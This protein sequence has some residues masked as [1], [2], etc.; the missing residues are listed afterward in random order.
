VVTSRPNGQGLLDAIKAAVHDN[1]QQAERGLDQLGRSGVQLDVAIVDCLRSGISGSRSPGVTVCCA[2]GDDGSSDRV[3]DGHAHVDFP[4]SSLTLWGAA[5]TPRRLGT[6][7]TKELSGMKRDRGRPRRP[8]AASS[9]CRL[10]KSHANV[11][12]SVNPGH[13]RDEASGHRGDAIRHRLY[14][15]IDDSSS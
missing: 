6:T 14:H 5:H 2:S 1:V 8:S 4:A 12:P 10:I 13:P 7:I 11:P 9:P 3:S 15:P